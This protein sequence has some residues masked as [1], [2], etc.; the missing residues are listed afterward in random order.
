M[1]TFWGVWP[2]DEKWRGPAGHQAHPYHLHASTS[3][4]RRQV[5]S[6][7]TPVSC[8]PSSANGSANKIKVKI[9]SYF[10]Y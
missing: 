5:Y 2:A 1:R 8:P 6:P 7:G 9:N 10:L 4:A 3:E